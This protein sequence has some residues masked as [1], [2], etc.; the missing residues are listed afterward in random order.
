[1]NSYLSKGSFMINNMNVWNSLETSCSPIISIH[2]IHSVAVCTVC[3]VWTVSFHQPIPLPHFGVHLH[4]DIWEI[5]ASGAPPPKQTN[6]TR[7]PVLVIILHIG[8]CSQNISHTFLTTQS[9][10]PLVGIRHVCFLSS[11]KRH[12]SWHQGN[13]IRALSK[14]NKHKIFISIIGSWGEVTFRHP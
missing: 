11:E 4:P 6:Y 12:V 7:Y 1:M 13:T 14:F 10:N 3:T 2:W 5:V 9:P 8:W